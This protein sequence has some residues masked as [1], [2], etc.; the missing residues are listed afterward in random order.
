V[1]DKPLQEIGEM[2]RGGGKDK[3]GLNHQEAQMY[4]R[5]GECTVIY[6]ASVWCLHT[7]ALLS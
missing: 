2:K 5:E 6:P 1:R 3:N 4:E 7:A